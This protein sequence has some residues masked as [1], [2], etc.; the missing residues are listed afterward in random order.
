MIK[1]ITSA[2]LP[3]DETYEIQKNHLVLGQGK[4]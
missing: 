3:V 2:N 4:K 1:T